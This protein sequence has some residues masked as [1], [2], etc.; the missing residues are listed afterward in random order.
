MMIDPILDKK[1]EETYLMHNHILRAWEEAKGETEYDLYKVAM[2][3]DLIILTNPAVTYVESLAQIEIFFHLT[4]MLEG[5]L[6]P[7]PDVTEDAT[8]SENVDV[9]TIDGM[10]TDDGF[11]QIGEGNTTTDISLTTNNEITLGMGVRKYRNNETIPASNGVYNLHLTP[12]ERWSFVYMAKL[13]ALVNSG[14][15]ELYDITLQIENEGKTLDFVFKSINTGIVL[16]N[17]KYNIT[18]SDGFTSEDF[19]VFQDIQRVEFYG[20]KFNDT[21]SNEN[22][23]PV[24]TFKFTY[25]AVR[26]YQH[27]DFNI[28]PVILETIANVTFDEEPPKEV[29]VHF[30]DTPSKMQVK[31]N[32][33]PVTEKINLVGD[34]PIDVNIKLDS[35]DYGD[36]PVQEIKSVSVKNKDTNE[37]ISYTGTF[38]DLTIAQ[39]SI[40]NIEVGYAKSIKTGNVKIIKD[41][42]V[43]RSLLNSNN[44]DNYEMTN[45]SNYSDTYGS[46][47]TIAIT[48]KDGYNMKSIKVNDVDVTITDVDF[49]IVPVKFVSD[50]VTVVTEL[51][52]DYQVI[53][54]SNNESELVTPV[55][56]YNISDDW[57]E[58]TMELNTPNLFP[59]T[60][61]LSVTLE[62]KDDRSY[63]FGSIKL[64]DVE[65]LTEPETYYTLDF[66]IDKSNVKI[67]TSV[68]DNPNKG[69]NII[70]FNYNVGNILTKID[71]VIVTGAKYYDPTT[72]IVLTVSNVINGQPERE[73]KKIKVISGTET[74]SEHDP[75]TNISLLM[76]KDYRIETVED[77]KQYT[78]TR[79][80]DDPNVTID[81]NGFYPIPSNTT[82]AHNVPVSFN[83]NSSGGFTVKVPIDTHIVKSVTLNGVLQ[84]IEENVPVV[85][86]PANTYTGNITIEATSELKP[87]PEPPVEG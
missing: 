54:T 79:T 29:R 68:V 82:L 85:S 6:K 41:A 77:F 63:M 34:A 16:V 9:S 15:T 69:K 49:M 26:R 27:P 44:F 13:E 8:E 19:K 28:N 62:L 66:A 45:D 56:Y 78:I 39:T 37:A 59:D 42:G 24:G 83:A 48:T 72:N 17:E 2:F 70:S 55:S 12:G 23:V 11:L 10:V 30:I 47:G 7:G 35:T 40:E 75:N 50:I 71:D 84:T 20:K 25:K 58:G 81:V 1:I 5:G 33:S 67:E 46:D 51:N 73:V 87:E 38:D 52:S 3:K 61:E 36:N 80:N 60:T 21:M 43:L 53:I 14:L 64:N 76:D 65:K 4:A 74:I 86:I 18:I 57:S 31:L 32:G 22:G